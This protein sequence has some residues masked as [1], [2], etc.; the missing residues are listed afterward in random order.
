MQMLQRQGNRCKALFKTL[1]KKVDQNSTIP[2]CIPSK[3]MMPCNA[4]CSGL[5]VYFGMM[6]YD[7]HRLG[8]FWYIQMSP[9][10][11]RTGMDR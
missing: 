2:K 1:E 7:A 10:H 8:V 3:G 9:E 4:S 5:W 6:P 11:Y